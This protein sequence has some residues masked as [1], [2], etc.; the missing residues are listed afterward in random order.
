MQGKN[1]D[2]LRF[3]LAVSR[4]KTIAGTARYL[5]VNES[6]VSRRLAN[7]EDR[8]RARVFD[9]TPSGLVL[10]EAGR[11]LIR[12]LELADREIEAGEQEISGSNERVAG[13]VR[14]TS[15]PMIVNHVLVSSLT[16]IVGEHPRLHIELIADSTDLSLMQR[17]ADIAVRLARPRSD[18]RAISQRIGS[19]KYAVYA[20]REIC[21]DANDPR[22]PWITY[23]SRMSELPQAG[24]IAA[25]APSDAADAP[26]VFVND[27]ETILQCL[28]NG[29]GKSLV[30]VA[31]GDR[32]PDL[33]RLRTE[34]DLPEREIWLLVHPDLRDLRRIRLTTKWIKTSI[35][36][37]LG[38]THGAAA[39]ESRAGGC[40]Q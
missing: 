11:A 27:A 23:E 16:R 6:T 19:L 38:N 40:R 3:L 10:T 17:E 35:R 14:V 12:H 30:P 2:D 34:R 32:D 1:W 21:A 20:A 28:K 4:S 25:N 7:A 5:R 22:L 24:W 33:V 26:R 9:K 36:R 18:M 29:I 15:V 8:L 13:N 39:R 31:L 37:F